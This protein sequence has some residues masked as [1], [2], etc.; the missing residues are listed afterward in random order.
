MMKQHLQDKGLRK[1]LGEVPGRLPSNFV[2]QTMQRVNEEV[3][4]REKRQNRRQ[5]W[6]AVCSSLALMGLAC[7]VVIRYV[8][9]MPGADWSAIWASLSCFSQLPLLLQ[10]LPPSLLCLLLFDFGLRRIYQKKE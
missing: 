10:L 2:F 4:I 6:A 9:E 8:G 5:M 1:A 7:L 3:R